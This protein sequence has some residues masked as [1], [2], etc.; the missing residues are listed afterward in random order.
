MIVGNVGRDAEFRQYM[1]QTESNKFT[2]SISFPLAIEQKRNPEDRAHWIQVK[3]PVVSPEEAESIM[4]GCRVFI[5]GR[6]H[7]WRSESKEGYDISATR[8]IIVNPP[9]NREASG[10]PGEESTTEEQH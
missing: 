3:L 7:G 5:E 6:L 9:R 8:V 2:G 10:F 1:Q 4:K